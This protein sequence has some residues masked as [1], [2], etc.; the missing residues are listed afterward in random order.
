MKLLDGREDPIIDPGSLE[1]PAGTEWPDWFQGLE[2][3]R[4]D[5]VHAE[6]DEWLADE[7]DWRC[8]DDYRLCWATVENAAFK[9]FESDE[10]CGQEALN[11][12]LIHGD[13]PGN[14]YIGAHLEMPMRK[15][16]PSPN[17][18]VGPFASSRKLWCP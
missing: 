2:G 11:N 14:N 4:R 17:G 1:E 16:T 6:P 7:P 15:P 3:N 9:Y 18:T 8:K 12:L 5:E 13:Y 10:P